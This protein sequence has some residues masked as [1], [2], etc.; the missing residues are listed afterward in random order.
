[1]ELSFRRML[2]LMALL[3]SLVMSAGCSRREP[4]A[5]GDEQL[6]GSSSGSSGTA[7][8]SDTSG[9]AGMSGRGSSADLPERERSGPASSGSSS[10][11]GDDAV[12]ATGTAATDTLI[13]G[14]VKAA[15]LA[16]SDL[17]SMGISV[18]T[19]DAEVT[20]SGALNNQ[21][22]IDRAAK[23]AGSISGVRSVRNQLSIKR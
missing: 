23:I 6:S 10:A 16:D 12:R 9:A 20:L 5:T 13:T 21:A 18:T 7:G 11:A 2:G 3:L 8:S 14:K 22:Q 15:L 19:T 17:K 1:M 4:A